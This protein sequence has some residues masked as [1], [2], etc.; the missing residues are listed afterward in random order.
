VLGGS[1]AVA[2]PGSRRA[3]PTLPDVREKILVTLGE[4]PLTP[5]ARFAA[6]DAMKQI[7]ASSRPEDRL[8]LLQ[9]LHTTLSNGKHSTRAAL[10]SA[11]ENFAARLDSAQAKPRAT[12]RTSRVSVDSAAALSRPP[13]PARSPSL[14]AGPAPLR[15]LDDFMAEAED[16]ARY[17]ATGT[18]PDHDGAR[19]KYRTQ[20]SAASRPATLGGRPSR[21]PAEVQSQP[22]GTLDEF[23]ADAER[24]AEY[25]ATGTQP[26]YAGAREKY[27]N[28]MP[29]ASRRT[30]P[31]GRSSQAPVEVQSQPF[32][33]LDEFFSDA[34][35]DADYETTGTQADYAGAREKFQN[36]TRG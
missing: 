26:D 28:Q 29:G 7:L 18:Q 15:T 3:G 9:Q 4:L 20:M 11:L 12:P 19:E 17:A 2:S 1:P 33:T 13:A 24:D 22:L 10:E 8:P 27:E 16:D 35:R 5:S 6:L 21:T 36:Q 32:R 34:E 25:E 14:Q 31:A 30:E 23:R